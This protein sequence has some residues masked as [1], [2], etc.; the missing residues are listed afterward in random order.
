MSAPAPNERLTDRAV[1]MAISVGL[2]SILL[3]IILG[4]FIASTRKT[5]VFPNWAENV[6]VSIGTAAALKL[7]DCLATLVALST[8]RSVERLGTQLGNTQPTGTG[9][10][11]GSGDDTVLDVNVVNPPSKPVP[12][13]DAPA[14]GGK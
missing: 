9:D 2:I 11:T 14:K 3:C 12:T 5:V 8:G 13:T 6:L 7:G 10:G 1:L 4:I